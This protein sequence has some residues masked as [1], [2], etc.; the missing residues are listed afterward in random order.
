[1]FWRSR[2]KEE[3]AGAVIDRWE[4]IKRR[5]VRGEDDTT[6]LFKVTSQIPATLRG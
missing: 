2:D 1:M 4:K 5:K 3:D 6:K